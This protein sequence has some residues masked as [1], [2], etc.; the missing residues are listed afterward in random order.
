MDTDP[1][2]GNA[3]GLMV[4]GQD[5]DED[6]S[7]PTTGLTEGVHKLY[8]RLINGDGRW[9]IYDKNVFY[10]SPNNENTANIASAEYFVDTDPGVGSATAL[11]VTGNSIDENLSLPTIG[12]T[13]GVHKLYVRLFNDDGSW[14]FYDKNVFYIN[15]DH[16][17]TANV[18]SAEYFIDTDPG[19]GNG[20]PL[21][22]TG[23]AIDQNSS[24]ATTGLQDGVH[25]LYLRLFNA[26]G[27]WSLYDSAGFYL[28]EALN[29]T[30]FLSEA[31]YFF[32]IDPG[33]G[34]GTPITFSEAEILDSDFNIDVPNDLPVGDHIVYVRVRNT[35]GTW[36][37]NAYSGPSTLSTT[38]T[39]LNN[40]RMYP[41]PAQDVLNFNTNNQPIEN[42]KIIDFNGQVVLDVI[43]EGFKLD[44]SHLSAGTYLIYLKTAIGSISKQ[45]IKQ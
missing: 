28:S 9:S 4:N 13:D 11:A 5:I 6:F 37:L 30:A 27:S 21:A 8:V 42:L 34:N 2:V 32:D 20:E 7:I 18:V 16:E 17:N 39:T 23:N 45:L 31:E 26:N 24:I 12:L 36:S 10:I 40:F 35:E 3:T 1:G 15:P 29:N 25:K 38:D 43:P 14:S 44:V 22:I 19:M 41:I 33:I